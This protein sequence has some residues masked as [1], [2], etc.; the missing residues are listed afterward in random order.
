MNLAVREFTLIV[1]GVKRCGKF[2][3]VSV[4]I[5]WLVLNWHATYTYFAPGVLHR[6]PV[7][8]SSPSGRVRALVCIRC[9]AELCPACN[10]Q[11][12]PISQYIVT[13]QLSTVLKLETVAGGI[14]LLTQVSLGTLSSLLI[15]NSMP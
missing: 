8:V 1:K 4:V 7:V 12:C 13:I 15:N 10:K 14:L 9:P 5:E 3:A 11:I 6:T 2:A